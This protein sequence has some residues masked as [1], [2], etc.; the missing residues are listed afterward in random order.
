MIWFLA[1]KMEMASPLAMEIPAYEPRPR[2]R[3]DQRAAE[4]QRLRALVVTGGV[5]SALVILTALAFGS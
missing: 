2:L 3:P 1:Y 5:G 4:R